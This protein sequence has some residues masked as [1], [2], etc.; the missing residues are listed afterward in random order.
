MTKIV[1]KSAKKRRKLTDIRKDNLQQILQVAEKI[2]AERGYSG[3]TIAAIADKVGLPKANV[4]YYFKTKEGLYQGVLNNLFT[5]WMGQM[6]E[7]TAD[8]HPSVALRNYIVNKVLQSKL[9]PN[10]SRIFAAEILHGALHLRSALE[11][12]LKEQFE[13][14]CQI[15]HCW[16]A[17]GWMDPVD[18]QHL[19]F[20][21]WSSTQAYADHA[22]Q[23]SILMGKESLQE[24]DFTQG[25][26][27]LTQ[28][29]LKGCGVQPCE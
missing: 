3:T 12:E 24:K 4:L 22:L 8:S 16:I 1:K 13:D 6:N 15:F 29:I 5:I 17:K 10:A 7:M 25:I 23:L 14:T 19:L 27:S 18:P 9:H 20:M 26:E 21:L 28:V 11:G 2:F